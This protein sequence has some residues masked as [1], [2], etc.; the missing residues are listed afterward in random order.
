MSYNIVPLGE[1]LDGKGYI[2]GPFGSALKRADML[3]SGIPVYEQQHA[4]NNHRTFRYYISTKKCESLSR[5][6]TEKNDLIISCSGTVGRIS[7]IKDEDPIGI[8]SQA[9]LI[10]RTNNEKVLADYLYYFL[11]SPKGKSE[12]LNASQGA[13]Q[14]NIAPRAVVEKIPV[15]LPSLAIQHVIVSQLKMLDNKILLN[16]Q[17][18]Q[19]LE[20][21]AQTIFQSWFVDFDPVKAQMNG[22]QPE[23]IDAKTAA[24]FPNKLDDATGIPENWASGS[25]SDI[26]D[27]NTKSWTKK[28]H[29]D[30]V[31]YVDLANT[32]NGAIESISIYSFDE[33]PSRARRVLNVGDTI[34]GTVR[35]GNRSFAYIGKTDLQL[36][37]STGFAVLSPKENFW[38]SFVYLCTTNDGAILEYARLADGGAYPA[39]KPGVIAS[40]E[41][42]IPSIE[43]AKEFWK[44]TEPMLKKTHQNRL[45]NEGL[46]EIRDILAPKLLSGEIE[47]TQQEAVHE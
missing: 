9:L 11:T 40:T 17:I 39:I 3:G 27:L 29:P 5:F 28:K 7:I 42:V 4:I 43:I 35:P 37:G 8:I 12:L 33:S 19:T 38:S 30:E 23:G 44:V 45:E 26:A 13:V 36:T 15:P 32:K 14:L 22:D 24:F 31:N 46:A 16:N 41:C 21:M 18:N 10:L 20:E 47:L 6:K 1:L 34:V 2:R 25:I